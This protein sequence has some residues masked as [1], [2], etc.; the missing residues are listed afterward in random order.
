MLRTVSILVLC[1]LLLGCTKDIDFE[2]YKV[3]NVGIPCDSVTM[4]I[5][6]FVARGSNDMP[7]G[8]PAGEDW[9]E[10]TNNTKADFKFVAGEWFVS[11]DNTDLEQYELPAFQLAPNALKVV[12]CSGL[13]GEIQGE[14]HANFKLSGGGDAI[15][16]SQKQGGS[17][18]VIDSIVFGEQSSGISYGRKPNACGPWK[19]FNQ[20]TPGELN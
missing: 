3:V 10:L 13:A 11:D 14:T 6:E 15:Y 4:A 1:V 2:P 8:S 12:W 17:I 5:N 9:F 19:N 16:L 7:S 20:T 18:Q